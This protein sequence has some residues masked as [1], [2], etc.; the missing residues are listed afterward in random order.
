MKIISCVALSLAVFISVLSVI[1]S[2]ASSHWIGELAAQPRPQYIICLA[3]CAVPIVIRFPRTGWCVLL[4]ILFNAY[5]VAP[6]YVRPA[7]SDGNATATFSV[8]HANV[9]R[10][11]ADPHAAFAWLRK[12]NATIVAM[13]EVTPEF[14]K[15]F[16]GALADYE[17]VLSHALTNS[18]GSAVLVKRDAPLQKVSAQIIHLPKD[19]ERPLIEYV[20]RVRDRE[21]ALLSLF[22]SRPIWQRHFAY[23]SLE[24]RETAR[25]AKEHQ[26]A[27]REVIVVGDLNIT[28]WSPRFAAL[29]AD[30]K[31]INSQAGFGLQSSWPTALP[32][33]AGIPI[34][35]CLHSA[36]IATVS[37]SIGSRIGSDHRPLLLHLK[38]TLRS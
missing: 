37:R 15:E 4:P 38:V 20:F 2:V 1:G 21:I 3:L 33:I 7:S 31:L 29:C 9:D 6:L 18:H 14:E 13:Q 24:L 30:G 23:Q 25:W 28:P 27:G 19:S 36:G 17:V 10:F 11:N 8:L 34:D 16:D 12:Q 22:V 32:S 26:A 35:H 5:Y